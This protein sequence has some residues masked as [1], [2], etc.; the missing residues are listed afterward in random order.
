[1][2]AKETLNNVLADLVW[3]FGFSLEDL[4]RLTL[5]ELNDWTEQANRQAKA[6]YARL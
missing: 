3:W 6:G 2:I 4:D 5:P 1:M